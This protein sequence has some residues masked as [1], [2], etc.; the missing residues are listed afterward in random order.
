VAVK[1]LEY[2]TLG[3]L[4]AWTANR[5]GPRLRLHLACGF[6]AGFVFGGSTLALLAP[7]PPDAWVPRAVNELF[8]P[9]G[10]ALALWLARIFVAPRQAVEIS[11]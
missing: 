11:N 4:L 5:Y 6:A 3:A 8:F 2:A 7:M 9:A 1:A 10:C